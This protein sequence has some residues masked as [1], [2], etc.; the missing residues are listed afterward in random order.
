MSW[1]CAHS[2]PLP[3][4]TI[5]QLGSSAGT[6]L[7]RPLAGLHAMQG[8][9]Q[10]LSQHTPSTQLLLAHSAA[11]A[12]ALPSPLLGTSQSPPSSHSA[13]VLQD[14]PSLRGVNPH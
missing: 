10:A 1:L 9:L 12:H 11:A 6:T 13:V 4:C 3:H 14:C 2:E 8:P 7:Q 5:G